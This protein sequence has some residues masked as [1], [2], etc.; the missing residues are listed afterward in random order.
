MVPKVF[1]GEELAEAILADVRARHPDPRGKRALI[2]RA[3]VARDVVPDA[4]RAAGMNVDVV[5]VYETR[6]AGAHDAVRLREMLAAREIDAVLV[7]SPSTVDSLCDL[8]GSE[9]ARMLSHVCVASI[10]SVTSDAARRRG[11]EPGVTAEVST[12]PGLIDA[13]EKSRLLR[14]EG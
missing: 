3:L 2:A 12:L 9:A 4:L 5:A 8:L 6:P 1:R 7:T 14:A 13:L 11:I 10:G